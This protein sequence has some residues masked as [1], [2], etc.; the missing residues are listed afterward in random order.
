MVGS[1]T[2][3]S[4]CT[5]DV[6]NVMLISVFYY[7]RPRLCIFRVPSFVPDCTRPWSLLPAWNV[8]G[9]GRRGLLGG[10]LS[11]FLRPV[12]AN[13]F[14]EKQRLRAQRQ[15]PLVCR[16]RASSPPQVMSMLF[17]SR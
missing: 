15:L 16:R 3:V 7:S 2:H 13:R 1:K 4:F 8:V 14:H 12:L 11:R 6:R 5:V 10:R 17:V 9:Y